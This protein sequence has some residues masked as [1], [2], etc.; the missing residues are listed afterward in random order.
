MSDAGPQAEKLPAADSTASTALASSPPA[1]SIVVGGA[2]A[3][4]VE[5]P[6]RE[7]RL[8]CSLDFRPEWD[9]PTLNEHVSGALVAE[10]KEMAKQ[11]RPLPD[12]GQLIHVMLAGTGYGKTHLFGRIAHLLG[13]QAFVVYVPAVEDTMRPL[14]HIRWHVVESY[15]RPRPNRLSVA[16][17]ALLRLC[18]PSFRKYVEEFPASL[19]EK[20]RALV[21]DLHNRGTPAARAVLEMVRTVQERGNL[22]AF[23]RLAESLA[24]AIPGVPAPVV[25]AIG[26]AWSPARD[27]ARRWLRGEE[28]P[29]AELTRLGLPAAAPLAS[30]VLQAIA[31]V[32]HYSIP[33]VICCDQLES[34]LKDK[35]GPRRFT[36]QLMEVLHSVPNQALVMGCLE[37]EWPTFEAAS[38]SPVRGQRFHRPLRLKHLQSGQAVELLSRRLSAWPAERPDPPA[39]S[40]PNP[41]WPFDAGSIAAYADR[42][43]TYPRGLIQ[44]C[45]AAFDEWLSAGRN[46]PISLNGTESPEAT[47]ALFLKEWDQE[48]QGIANDPRRSAAN[49]QE[50]RLFRG[51]AACLALA[52]E[53]GWECGGGIIRKITENVIRPGGSG[54]RYGLKIDLTGPAHPEGAGEMA[55]SVVLA[56][57]KL[58][59]GTSFRAYFDALVDASADASTFC[60]LV[61]EKTSFS[62]GPATRHDFDQA[63]Q[64]GKLRLFTF[65]EHRSAFERIECLL[66]M[67]DKAAAGDLSL[68]GRTIRPEECRRLMIVA[69][70]LEGFQLFDVLGGWDGPVAKDGNQDVP[71]APLEGPA[72]VAA[73]E[74]VEARVREQLDLV[75][76]KLGQ[77]D[78]PV[79]AD[80]YEI[81]AEF[82]RLRIRPKGSRTSLRRIAEKAEELRVALGVD[83]A[84]IIGPQAGYI[85]ID[86]QVP[87]RA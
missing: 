40:S 39:V 2:D 14:E 87:G 58:D 36:A 13:D 27:S 42:E 50:E 15:F 6:L 55:W 24:D 11:R 73:D 82:V 7:S 68:G 56:V 79:I 51:I 33:T 78:Q 47:D 25:K 72:P 86:V 48:L 69:G 20:H 46:G 9:V 71:A 5:N 18:Y 52:R 34:L 10:I 21:S 17:F 83:V 19:A 37:S 41:V 85:S 76:D 29:E 75:V 16:E 74:S 22:P 26:L 54:K 28:L 59:H 4:P 44:R 32:H 60:L 31:A 30:H 45:S 63:R 57:T 43:L 81:G 38:F 49:T 12:P 53:A 62:M 61:H 84:P 70:V 1:G 66:R 64:A 23:L 35:D 8:N 65:E 80:G 77:W 3:S 67:L